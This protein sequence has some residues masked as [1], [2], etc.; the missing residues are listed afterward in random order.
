MEPN[1]CTPVIEGINTLKRNIQVKDFRNKD[2]REELLSALD[3]NWEIE[4]MV[5]FFYKTPHL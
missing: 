4:T 5:L 1:T 3:D 2:N